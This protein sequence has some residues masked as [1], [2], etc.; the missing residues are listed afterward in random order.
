ML[1]YID[2]CRRYNDKLEAEG[3]GYYDKVSFYGLDLYSLHASCKAVIDYL[4]KVDPDAAQKARK[5]YG[6]FER[7]GKDTMTY[8]FAARYGL[9]ESAEKEVVAVL[10]DLCQKRCEYLLKQL[11]DS[12]PIEEYQFAAE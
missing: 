12:G 5:R 7:F 6:I 8:A 9:V 1:N 10:K 4:Q 3:K 11:K 2:W